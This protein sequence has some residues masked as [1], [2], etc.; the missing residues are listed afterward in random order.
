MRDNH[1]HQLFTQIDVGGFKRAVG[2]RAEVTGTRGTQQGNTGRLRGRPDV[3]PFGLQAF[4][5]GKVC[6]HD[7]AQ[8]LGLF[9]GVVT[10]NGAVIV[11]LVAHQIARL[12][13][14]LARRHD[15]VRTGVLL[16]GVRETH[17]EGCRRCTSDLPGLDIDFPTAGQHTALIKDQCGCQFRCISRYAAVL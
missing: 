6:Q 12:I 11:D 16:H 4:V 9:V 14:V 2:Q 10:D 13:T 7:L 1:V 8:H 5:V 3:I 15:V 17:F